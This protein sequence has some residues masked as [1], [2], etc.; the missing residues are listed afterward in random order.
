MSRWWSATAIGVRAT[1]ARIDVDTQQVF[2]WGR[3]EEQAK[4][5][6]ILKLTENEPS[7]GNI[8]AFASQCPTFTP[9]AD[10]GAL[11]EP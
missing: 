10:K 1:A 5:Y 11:G 9:P 2:F 7:T 3:T 6:A 8:K 4:A